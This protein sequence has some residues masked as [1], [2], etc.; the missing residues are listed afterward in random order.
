ME[1][2]N[3]PIDVPVVLSPISIETA[4][5]ALERCTRNC[6]LIMDVKGN[7]LDRIGRLGLDKRVIDP[8]WWTDFTGWSAGWSGTVG[9]YILS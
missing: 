9:P 5:K 7:Y 3:I 8:V 6:D 4:K 2:P 1:E